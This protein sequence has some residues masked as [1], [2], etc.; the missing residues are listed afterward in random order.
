MLLN[1]DYILPAELTGYVREAMADQPANQFQLARWL[2]NRMVDDLMYRF[3]RGTGGLTEA[4]EYR[5]YDAE[6]P[7]GGRKGIQRVTGELPPISRKIRLG[8]Y[9]RL[10]Q[11]RDPNALIR[12]GLLTD[13]ETMSRQVA[14]RIELA[15]GDALVNGSV[16]INENGVAAT[17]DFGRS[18][19]HSVTAATL[20]SDTANAKPLEDL[21]SWQDTYTDTN[22]VPPGAIV[23]SRPVLGYVLRNAELRSDAAT[24]AGTPSI[25]TQTV[26]TAL[27]QAHGLPPF[28]VVDE[29]VSVVGTSTRVIPATVA[30]LLPEPVDPND[31]AGTQLGATMW[32]TTAESLDPS[33]QLAEGDEPGLVAGVYSTQDPIALWTK[34]AG[35]ALPVAANPDLSFKAVV[36]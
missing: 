4:A 2:P 28:Y 11:R 12:N 19:A 26:L 33:Y 20:W 36:A 22:G 29:R 27:L 24:V 30:L 10:R 14:A 1:T 6:S 17:A 25:I 15:R 23:F 16:T 8:E 3:A 35:I 9:D 32:G 34:A 31:E 7:I 21:L 18:G 5:A 13:S